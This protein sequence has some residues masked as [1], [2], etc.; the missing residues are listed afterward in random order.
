MQQNIYDDPVFFAKYQAMRESGA[1]LNQ[2]LEQPAV[3]SLLPELNGKTVLDLGCGTG[4]LSRY[5]VRQGAKRVVGVDISKKMLATARKETRDERIIFIESAI[6]DFD[7]TSEQFDLTVSSLAFHYLADL[8]A[9]FG[10][11]NA[12]LKEDGLIVFSMEHPIITCSQ[13]IHLGWE[14]DKTGQK[15]YWQ[16]DAYSQEGIRR[17][18]WHVDGVVR[19]HRKL[20]S[21]L[22]S[23]FSS[24]FWINKI[25]EPH[26][27]EEAEQERPW[28][29]EERR[30]PP[31]LVVRASKRSLTFR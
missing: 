15:K 23:L 26:A 2:V 30:R 16:V 19:Y 18:H 11:I 25:W 12:C 7:F 20:S 27:L 17:S 21:I 9:V 31:F 24:G 8:D 4:V 1:E 28:L 6:E 3:R 13:G 14:T 22:N 10:K 29:L 5:L